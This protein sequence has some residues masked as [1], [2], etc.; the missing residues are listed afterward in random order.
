[1][2][3][4][5]NRA[6]YSWKRDV[7]RTLFPCEQLSF[8]AQEHHCRVEL[9]LQSLLKRASSV[10]AREQHGIV[11]SELSGGFG[12]A[13]LTI[14]GCRG[15]FA[16]DADHLNAFERELVLEL[17]QVRNRRSARLAPA[18]PEVEKDH[19]GVK[20]VKRHQFSS[21]VGKL[22]I[23]QAAASGIKTAGALL[24][25][26]IDWRLRASKESGEC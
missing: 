16:G 3:S 13:G 6:V 1:M 7:G 18:S 17:D 20:V 23:D 14:S 11:D 19:V 15:F 8:A 21:Q 9:D 24:D 26:L 2:Q 22:E 25:G 4:E 10:A 12:R 5:C